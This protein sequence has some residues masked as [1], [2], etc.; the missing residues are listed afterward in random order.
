MLDEF[1]A[2]EGIATE[3]DLFNWADAQGIDHAKIEYIFVRLEWMSIYGKFEE[4]V[5][6]TWE[7][8]HLYG[9]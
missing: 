3:A 9:M 2:Q 7:A 6:K 1:F 4:L 5:D 8:Q